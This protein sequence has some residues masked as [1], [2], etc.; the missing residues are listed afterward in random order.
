[1]LDSRTVT[2]YIRST[3]RRNVAGSRCKGGV[4]YADPCAH[5]NIRVHPNICNAITSPCAVT[6]ALHQYAA[7]KSASFAKTWQQQVYYTSLLLDHM[8]FCARI[9][10]AAP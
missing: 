6:F 10:L 8:N 9:L 7:V 3:I 5:V 4:V 1:M 2:A